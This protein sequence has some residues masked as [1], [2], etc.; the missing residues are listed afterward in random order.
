MSEIS[1]LIA[2]MKQQM[3]HDRLRHEEEKHRYEEE[4][5]E[6]KQR[7]EEE[8]REEKQRHE[9]EK[10][11]EQQRHEEEKRRHAEAIETLL[12]QLSDK[13]VVNTATATKFEAFDSTSELWSNYYT[14]FCTFTKANSIPEEKKTFVFLT[15][16]ST[17]VYRLLH[18]LAAQQDDSKDVND[19][20]IDDIRRFMEQQFD[21]TKFVVRERSKFWSQPK[22]K[23]GE[24]INELAARIR[25]YGA[26]CDF[27]RI[28]DPQDEAFRTAFICLVNNEAVTKALYKLKEDELSFTK[29]VE[30]ANEIE[31]AAKVA[32][33]SIFGSTD[34][35]V[36]KVKARPNFKKKKN[37]SAHNKDDEK[38]STSAKV[39]YR[40]AKKGHIAND[41]KYKSAKC[42]FCD[43]TGH[44]EAACRKKQTSEVKRISKEEIKKVKV[45]SNDKKLPKLEAE[46]EINGKAFNFE[47]DTG[48]CA[49]FI[50]E[51]FWR[52]IGKPKLQNATHRY[53]SAT[54]H[55]LPIMGLFKASVKYGN[56]VKDMEFIV[57]KIPELNLLGRDAILQMNISLD[58]VIENFVTEDNGCNG[59][60]NKVRDNFKP[61]NTLQKACKQL[62]AEFPDLFKPELGCLKDI[63]LEIKFKAEAKPVFCKPRPVPF[64]IQEDLAQVYDAGIK[65]GIWK[66]TQF[67]EYGTPVVPIRKTLLPGQCKRSLRVCGDYSVTVNPQLETHR[68]PLPLPEDLMRKLGGGYG[69]TK[70]DL[71]DAYNQIALGPESQRRLA[72]STHKGVLLQMRLPFGISSAPGYFQEIM[73][74]LTGDLPGVAVYLDDILISGTTAEEHLKNLR[75]LFTRLN[76]KGLRCRLEKCVFAQ[77]SVEYLGHRLSNEGISKGSKVDAV[78]G[79]PAPKDV[80]TLRSFLG[81]VQF[82]GKFLP[83]LSSMSEPLHRL[84]R[85]N[86][87]WKWGKEEEDAFKKLKESLQEDSVLAHFDP[88]LQIGLSCDASNVGIGAVLFHRYSDGSERPI[89]NASKTLTSTER[90]YSQ[91]QK[92]ALSIIFGLKKFHQFL[93][94][95]NFILVTDHKPL[96]A[97][98]GPDKATPTLAAN[99]LARWSLLLSQYDYTIEYRKTTEHG[100]AD[101]LSRLPIGP[102]TEFD[103]EESGEDVDTVCTINTI[104]LQLKPND[105]DALPKE[106]AKDAILSKVIRYT[107]EGW[108]SN[109]D[110]CDEM[111][112]FYKNRE[113]LTTC[114]G[115]LLYGS[116]VVIP[117][118][119]RK[120]VLDL[121]HLGHFGMERMKQLARTA[122][123]WPHIDEDIMKASRNCTACGEHQNKPSKPP[124]HPW[125][126]P[127]KPWSRIHVDHAINFMGSNWMVVVDAY[128]KYP[129]IHMTQSVS[130]KSTTELLEQDFAHFGYPHTIVS[131]NATT[132]MSAEFKEWCKE[133]GIVHLTGAPYHPAT[134]GAAERLVQT[135]KKALRKSN[136][137]PRH[138]LQEFLLQYRRTPTPCGYSPSELLNGR[139][140]RTK[141]DALLPSPVHISQGKQMKFYTKSY[142]DEKKVT[143][144]VYSFKVGD[145]CYALY[146]GP[147]RDKDARWV[148]AVIKKRRGSRCF[149]IKVVPRGP[150]WRRHLEQLKPRY[151][152]TEDAEPGEEP[153]THIHDSVGVPEVDVDVP[154]VDVDGPEVD[155]KPPV[156]ERAKRNPRLPTGNEYGEHNPRRSSRARKPNKKYV[157]KVSVSGKPQVRWGGV[158]ASKHER[159]CHSNDS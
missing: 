154:E 32:K 57:T 158:M 41:C 86:A 108:P 93:Y 152:T 1:D 91:I 27:K 82:Y 102:D 79:M 70:I 109:E 114:N 150:T 72:L 25:R 111:K 55:H 16:Q 12:K 47:L 44:L 97:M 123:Y 52:K 54:R 23:P 49:N 13:P 78:K 104:S 83:N 119:L 156:A 40:C 96:I 100:N 135:F 148:P 115:C 33:E 126:L 120:H 125:M 132:F 84:T 68:Q 2:V 5:R 59:N 127:E 137:P 76:E 56:E 4:K 106:T 67:N 146:Y 42:N 22:R 14:R 151:A 98:F 64:A 36:N 20:T 46:I 61:D 131:D 149:D 134:N 147:R 88:S 15:N 99:R 101:A 58:K 155:I 37:P 90:N 50:T 74:Q 92:E 48:A 142:E 113:S 35:S 139:Q 89:A 107:R 122:V 45:L 19:L 110:R 9:E 18:N 60:V 81:S 121:L 21:P 103:G 62:C 65:K 39:C 118:T 73:E 94:G 63:E 85:K 87:T 53:E 117:A 133:R 26:T 29:A 105:S 153:E 6:E 7:H 80:S 66:P 38:P 11:E 136:L 10:R 31:D 116:R 8:K 75:R 77:S 129:C 138:A 43:I 51:E 3:E 144:V 159:R 128:S 95:R 145:P 71:A 28:K 140:I 69:F 112:C 130:T 34:A 157:N 143:K 141:I 30:K 24:T 17:D 124:V